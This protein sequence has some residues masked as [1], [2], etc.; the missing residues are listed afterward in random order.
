MA[1]KLWSVFTDDMDHCMFTGSADIERHHCIGKTR[2]NKELCEEYGYIAP[3]RR[4]LHPNGVHAGHDAPLI[5]KKLK[6]MCQE[7]YEAKH[8]TREDFI[9]AFG[10]S[11]L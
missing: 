1:K 9:K 8:G 10:R 6:Q 11:Y 7:D 3:L 2:H 5:D 4:D